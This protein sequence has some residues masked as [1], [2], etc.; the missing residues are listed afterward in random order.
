MAVALGFSPAKEK[1][2]DEKKTKKP[3]AL[4]PCGKRTATKKTAAEKT[5]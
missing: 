1:D 5:V 4:T 3:E 2:G